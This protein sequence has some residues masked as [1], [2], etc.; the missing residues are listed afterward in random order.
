MRS[1]STNNRQTGISIPNF[2]KEEEIGWPEI[3]SIIPRYQS[4]IIE[5]I[6]N[7]KIQ[8]QLRKNLKIEELQQI[9]EFCHQ[10]LISQPV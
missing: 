8:F 2:I 4:I 10:H 7:K 1:E 3:K 9:D 5:K 6:Q